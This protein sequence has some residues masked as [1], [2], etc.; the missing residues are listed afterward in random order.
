MVKK[1]KQNAQ[2]APMCESV[3]E[4]PLPNGDIGAAEAPV[5]KCGAGVNATGERCRNGHLLPGH[6]ASLIVGHRSM[7]FWNAAQDA[8]AALVGD[9]LRDAG[10]SPDDAPRALT[11][12]AEGLAQAVL[13]RDAAFDRLRVVG[14]P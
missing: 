10:H 1:A 11:V 9:V 2:A 3:C 12:A 5:C 8:L 4:T 14:G 13:I 6:T 7:Q